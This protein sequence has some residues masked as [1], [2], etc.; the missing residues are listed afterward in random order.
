[1]GTYTIRLL[2]CNLYASSDGAF[3]FLVFW[4]RTCAMPSVTGESFPGHCKPESRIGR[5]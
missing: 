3:P 4:E 1:M 5:S 2:K